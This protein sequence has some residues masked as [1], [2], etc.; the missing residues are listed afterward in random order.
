LLVLPDLTQPLCCTIASFTQTL[1]LMNSKTPP[2]NGWTHPSCQPL[3]IL[4]LTCQIPS[5]SIKSKIFQHLPSP[6]WPRK[7]HLSTKFYFLKISKN[8]N[9][10]V[11]PLHGINPVNVDGINC[12]LNSSLNTGE[13]ASV[14]GPSRLF[15]LMLPN[16]PTMFFSLVSYTNG[17]L[18]LRM[19]YHW[20]IS[21][22]S[23][24]LQRINLRSFP[25]SSYKWGLISCFSSFMVWRVSPN[26]SIW[27]DFKNID[28]TPS[29]Q[30]LKMRWNYLTSLAPELSTCKGIGS[31]ARTPISAK[32]RR[33][34]NFMLASIL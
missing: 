1:L 14:Q 5:Y 11:G 26:L 27:F 29:S 33:N 15:T 2:R 8:H 21:L 7:S 25:K 4:W 24:E 23:A 19:V 12:L 18:D 9:F 32:R 30:S 3:F 34:H 10:L 6:R 31:L 28:K 20:D 13:M 16:P 17:L 22:Q